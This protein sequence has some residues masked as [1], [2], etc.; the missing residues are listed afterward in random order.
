MYIARGMGRQP[1]VDKI[2]MS[3]QKPCHFSHLLQDLKISFNTDFIHNFSCFIHVY[4]PGAGGDNP[5]GTVI[6]CKLIPYVTG[7]LL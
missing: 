1:S 2:L 7:H 6:L 3:T 4:S 5:L